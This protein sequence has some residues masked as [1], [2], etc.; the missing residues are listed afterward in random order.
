MLIVSLNESSC[1]TSLV[2]TLVMKIIRITLL[3]VKIILETLVKFTLEQICQN[4]PLSKFAVL[5]YFAL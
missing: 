3:P 4:L 1:K 2:L 5:Q